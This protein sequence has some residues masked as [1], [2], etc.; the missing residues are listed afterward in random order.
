MT[1]ILLVTN[2]SDS[3]A[4]RAALEQA[5]YQVTEAADSTAAVQALTGLDTEPL[6]VLLDE[7]TPPL[8]GSA[9][10]MQVQLLSSAPARRAFLLLTDHPEQVP[11]LFQGP[12]MR[13]LL[14]VVAKSPGVAM[15]LA[16][17]AAAAARLHES[18]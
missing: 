10:L 12:R 7:G 15:V 18:A 6:V 1:R 16:A 2:H 13:R 11:T 8:G 4:L 17:V 3:Q 5:D 14:P 9:L